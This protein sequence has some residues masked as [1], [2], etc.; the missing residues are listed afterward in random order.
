MTQTELT[1]LGFKRV[2]IDDY[3][4]DI[5]VNDFYYEAQYGEILF[6]SGYNDEAEEKDKWFVTTP[7]QTLKFYSYN[8]IK[9][10]MDIFNRNKIF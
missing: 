8:E 9:T 4:G 10:V 6:L 7:C 1:K 3:D 5:P 2:N